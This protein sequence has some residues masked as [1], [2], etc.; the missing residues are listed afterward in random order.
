MQGVQ[1]EVHPLDHR[2]AGQ[3]HMPT[4]MSPIP[5]GAVR[6]PNG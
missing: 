5:S 2:F 6:M 3:I 4:V 1:K